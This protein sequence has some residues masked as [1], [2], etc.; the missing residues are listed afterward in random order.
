MVHNL[1]YNMETIIKNLP[2]HPLIQYDILY[3]CK[4]QEFSKIHSISKFSFIWYSK[5]AIFEGMNNYSSY[6]FIKS[7]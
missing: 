1:R 2:S 5:Q 7:F 4:P 3:E 6:V